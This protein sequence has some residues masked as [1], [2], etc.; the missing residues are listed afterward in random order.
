MAGVEKAAEHLKKYLLYYTLLILFLALLT[1][2][3]EKPL[4]HMPNKI[5]SIIVEVLAISAIFPSM[6]SLKGGELANA[7]R[8]WKETIISLVYLYVV[9]PLLTWL[10]A[11]MISNKMIALGYFLSNIVPSSSAALGYV[12]LAMGNIELGTVI[13]ILAFAL[14]FAAVPGYLTLYASMASIKIPIMGLLESLGIVLLIPITAGQIVRYSVVRAKG[15]SYLYK[16]IMPA[17]SIETM[18][19]ILLLVYVLIAKRAL[20]ILSK[21]WIALEIIGYQTALVLITIPILIGINKSLGVHYG[22]H[23]AMTF[24]VIT[25]NESVAAAIAASSLGGGLAAIPPGLIPAIQPVLAITYLHLGKYVEKI[26]GK[27]TKV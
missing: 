21:P 24:T 22:E 17:L 11:S 5:Y 2:P 15:Q 20:F 26:L 9:S 23:Q 7:S 14:A 18:L 27:S 6:V 4:L 1:G 12:M 13:V 8:M 19:S 10:F 25:R 3:R 16:K